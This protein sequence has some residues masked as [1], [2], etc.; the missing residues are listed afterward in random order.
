MQKSMLGREKS[1]FLKSKGQLLTGQQ[2]QH[3]ELRKD[4]SGN[5][6]WSSVPQSKLCMLVLKYQNVKIPKG[7]DIQEL[8]KESDTIAEKGVAKR[9]KNKTK[10]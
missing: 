10:K 2:M 4:C 1:F 7:K 9:H 3:A 6:V 5:D 8:F